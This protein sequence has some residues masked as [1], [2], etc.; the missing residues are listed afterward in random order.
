[1]RGR[2]ARRRRPDVS[3]RTAVGTLV[4]LA[5]LAAVAVGVL[6]VPASAV[7]AAPALTWGIPGQVVVAD[8]P[9]VRCPTSVGI[10]ASRHV[11]LPSTIRAQVSPALASSV[12]VFADGLDTLNVVAPTTWGCTALDSVAGSST[13]IVY[14]PGEPA[15]VWGD[16]TAVR[17]GIV[18]SQTG[19]CTGCS[20]EVA[21]P[22]FAAARR[23]YRATYRVGCA[24]VPAR[25]E[26]RVTVATHRVLF[27][28]PP[29]VLGAGKPSG[30]GLAAYG[31]VLWHLRGQRA[32]TAWLDTCTLPVADHGLCVLSVRD[33]LAR[34][35]G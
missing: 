19:S 7:P 13:L 29:G 34:H 28:D 3:R 27:I 4:T 20:L 5:V 16:V 15:P 21:C 12:S 10:P 33:F 11:V 23:Q 1:M 25:G 35:P 18:A 32:E 26:Q 2:H 24:G 30:G 6:L 9:V 22:L 17:T 8:L 14:P 31:A